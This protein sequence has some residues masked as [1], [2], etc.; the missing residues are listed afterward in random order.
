MDG[1]VGLNKE[2]ETIKGREPVK[3]S[4]RFDTPTEYYNLSLDFV[5]WEDL[6]YLKNYRVYITPQ[7]KNWKMD[8]KSAP[9]APS[10]DRSNNFYWFHP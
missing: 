10:S 1:P 8:L 6:Y 3:R 5:I 2:N 7:T 4:S 9:P